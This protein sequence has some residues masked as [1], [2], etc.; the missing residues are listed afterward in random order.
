MIQIFKVVNKDFKII[1]ISV[2]KKKQ[3]KRWKNGRKIILMEVEFI[4]KN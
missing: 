1:M 4:K 2:F 3:S